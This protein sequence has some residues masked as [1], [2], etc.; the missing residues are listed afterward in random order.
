[1]TACLVADFWKYTSGFDQAFR[2]DSKGRVYP[3]R[4]GSETRFARL[5]LGFSARPALYF[6]FGRKPLSVPWPS[7]KRIL[8]LCC[9]SLWLYEMLV[10]GRPM[11]LR[12]ACGIWSCQDLVELW[13]FCVNYTRAR[14][15]APIKD[16]HWCGGRQLLIKTVLSIVSPKDHYCFGLW[17]CPTISMKGHGPSLPL[18]LRYW[19]KPDSFLM[20]DAA[21]E[22]PPEFPPLSGT[23]QTQHNWEDHR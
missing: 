5:R 1:M 19:M 20:A 2:V 10:W 17:D 13:C 23:S 16:I 6:L 4:F 3:V 12:F 14:S 22:N 15:S 7:T 18:F 9:T 11:S 21:K 8:L